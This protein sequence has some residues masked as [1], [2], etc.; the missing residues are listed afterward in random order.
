MNHE[1]ASL[2]KGKITLTE[3]SDGVFTYTD[4]FFLKSGCVG[5]YLDKKELKDLQTVVNYY[6]SI[7]DIDEIKVSIGGEYV[8]R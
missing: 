7:D 6:F 1:A 2:E 8:S 5:F 4:K 3:Y